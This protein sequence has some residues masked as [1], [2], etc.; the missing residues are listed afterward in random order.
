MGESLNNPDM[1]AQIEYGL[2]AEEVAAINKPTQ[3]VVLTTNEIAALKKSKGMLSELKK[4][5]LQ[6]SIDEG[7]DEGTESRG[8]NGEHSDDKH[9]NDDVFKK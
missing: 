6:M 9:E 5:Q 1:V 4:K 2:T 3:K 8:S 7:N